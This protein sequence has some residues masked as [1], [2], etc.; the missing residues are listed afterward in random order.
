MARDFDDLRCL[1]K[2]GQA[3]VAACDVGAPHGGP[4]RARGVLLTDATGEAVFFADDVAFVADDARGRFLD[5]VA[6][7]LAVILEPLARWA[8]DGRPVG[9]V[10]ADAGEAFKVFGVDVDAARAC[11]EQRM[12]DE[13]EAG[14]A[15]AHVVA[16]EEVFETGHAAQGVGQVDA[17]P[18]LDGAVGEG[19]R[20]ER[21]EG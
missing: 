5:A 13:R 18:F 1:V 21:G 20:G 7:L 2:V 15:E 3:D 8:I 19:E 4:I 11:V 16:E 9:V 10:E 14:D 12:E 17:A 6:A